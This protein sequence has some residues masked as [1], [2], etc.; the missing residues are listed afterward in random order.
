MLSFEN[1]LLLGGVLHFVILI[2]SFSVP[3]VLNWKE[4]L[5]S[6]SPFVKNL[7][8]VYGTFIVIMIIGFG[9]LTLLHINE[10]SAGESV[11]RSLAAF[12]ALF[13]LARLVVQ[14]FI[15]DAKPILTNWFFKMGYHGLT[16][17]FM[18]LVGAL[19]L[20]GPVQFICNWAMI[21]ATASV[22]P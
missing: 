12:I 8:W 4:E 14:F 22:K 20:C 5:K 1:L 18:F 17:I 3:I 16:V 13:W 21:G 7:F 15:F 2:A 10:M 6:L 11:A 9:T 19:W